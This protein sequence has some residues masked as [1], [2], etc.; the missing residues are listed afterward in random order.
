[1][2]APPLCCAPRPS[3][4]SHNPAFDYVR[5]SSHQRHLRCRANL[6]KFL[7][8]I[9]IFFFLEADATA[10]RQ[11][12]PKSPPTTTECNL[13]LDPPPQTFRHDPKPEPRP[14][15]FHV[16]E[17]GEREHA[18][19]PTPVEAQDADPPLPLH[20]RPPLVGAERGEAL[21]GH[22]LAVAEPS[23]YPAQ[24]TL[25]TVDGRGG[26]CV[27]NSTFGRFHNQP[28]AMRGQGET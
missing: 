25:C 28:T 6:P 22:V 2:H 27:S 3:R 11:A 23:P 26:E 18:A 13:S 21:V 1:L 10:A 16:L 15:L 4:L 14:H 7:H 24:N 20:L 19:G 17:E 5:H 12:H 8:E 9:F